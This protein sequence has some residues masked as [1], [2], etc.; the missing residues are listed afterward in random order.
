MQQITSLN[1][2]SKE[3]T[4]VLYRTSVLEVLT[5]FPGFPRIHI[6]KGSCSTP[7]KLI[8]RKSS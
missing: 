2:C 5:V 7:E 8:T 4:E 6:L 3:V 1:K